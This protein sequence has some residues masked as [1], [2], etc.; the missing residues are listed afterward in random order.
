MPPPIFPTRLPLY[1]RTPPALFPLCL[2]FTGLALAWK[3]GA[4]T[5]GYPGAIGDVM[6]G[7]ISPL[8]VIAA[9]LYIR[10]II[11]EPAAL[12]QDL[13]SP[14]GRGALSAAPMTM[15]LM[16]FAY[17]PVAEDLAR[18]LWIAGVF[19]HVCIAALLIEVMIHMPK[20]ARPFTPALYVPFVGQVLAPIA[21]VPL[22]YEFVSTILFVVA[23][24]IWAILT[25]PIVARFTRG[26]PQPPV[27]PPL[28][29][30]LASVALPVVAHDAL[31]EAFKADNLEAIF[32]TMAA[33][34]AVVLLARA[35][36]LTEGGWTPLWASFTFP[37]AAFSSACFV[38]A[39][40]RIG[41][42]WDSIAAGGL[43]AVTLITFY[44]GYR[45]AKAAKEGELF[46]APVI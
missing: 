12:R 44:V 37:F 29:I 33:L 2:G 16:S 6:I 32:F 19:L 34:V 17:L 28:A 7:L 10:K 24:L 25:G 36:W 11:A 4:L 41:A 23:I 42:I 46:R 14:A 45:F 20:S 1:A 13:R 27:R 38:M 30:I 26:W 15:M 35:P 8:F 39:E 22:G 9:F 43:V 21:G 31:P 40:N 18:A 5:F 3:R